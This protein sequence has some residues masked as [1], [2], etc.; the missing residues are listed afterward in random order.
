[1][2][3]Y[4]TVELKSTFIELMNTKKS[5]VIIGAIYRQPN[6]D[7]DD[8]N[9]IYFNPLVDKILK[10]SKLIFLLDVDLLKCDHH[11]PTHYTTN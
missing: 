9:D 3:I 7:L 6:M 11:A 10:E 8:F 1:M 5:N 4:E 2:C